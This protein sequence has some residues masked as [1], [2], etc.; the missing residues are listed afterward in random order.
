MSRGKEYSSSLDV[1]MIRH[2]AQKQLG[3]E[4]F[5]WLPLPGHGLSFIEVRAGTQA[6]T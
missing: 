5:T 4:T 3:E 1:A 6:G 2:S